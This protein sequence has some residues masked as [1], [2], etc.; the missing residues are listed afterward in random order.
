VNK[1]EDLNIP[2]VES[3]SL[4]VD[5]SKF[6]GTKVAIASVTRC[7]KE[8]HWI[9]GKF[10]KD[11][12]IKIPAVEIKTEAITE[13]TDANGVKKPITVSVKLN[14]QKQINP[15]TKKE[16]IV[17]SKG[18]KA[19]LWKFM[20]KMAVT[21]LKDLVGKKVALT[22]APSTDPEDDRMWLKIVM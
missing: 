19:Q 7:E 17:I 4:G 21:E 9:D 8:T 13:I 3:K 10:D 2:V 5:F 1:L 20:R 18:P 15:D 12:T 14:L 6:D 22:L 11:K 16:E